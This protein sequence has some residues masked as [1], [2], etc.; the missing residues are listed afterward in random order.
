LRGC[1]SGQRTLTLIVALLFSG[2]AA[3]VVEELY[4]RGFLLPR[5]EHMGWAAPLWNSLLFA[6]YHF[7]FPENVLVIFVGFLPISYVVWKTRNVR[8]GI[9]VHGIINMWGVTQL[10]GALR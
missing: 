2:V 6:L 9:I 4:F 8:I 3:P 7:Y 5:M 1:S 10:F